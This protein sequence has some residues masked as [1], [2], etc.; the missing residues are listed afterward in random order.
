MKKE[1]NHFKKGESKC[2][3]KKIVLFV[4]LFLFMFAF[5][6][7]LNATTTGKLEIRKQDDVWYTKRG[8]GKP[9]TSARFGM[10]Y[11]DGEVVFCLEP[12]VEITT[13]TYTGEFGYVNSPYTE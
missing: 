10:Y 2:F 4:S 13:D 12:G 1:K 8:G 9:Y 3:T 7:K 11:L 5:T 6:F